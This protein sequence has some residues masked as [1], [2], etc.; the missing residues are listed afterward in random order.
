MKRLTVWVLILAMALAT[1]ATF[2]TMAMAKQITV[3]MLP[4]VLGEPY[5]IASQKGAELAAKELGIKFIF[6]GPVTADVTKQIEMIDNYI[7]RGVDVIAVSPNDANAIAPI[8]KKAMSKGIKVITW[9]ADA[10]PSARNFFVNQVTYEGVGKALV[11]VLADEIGGKGEVAIVTASLTAANQN[12]WIKYMKEELKDY[13][14]MKL[15]DIR[16]S[17]EDQQ[18]AFQVTTDLMTAYPNLRGVFAITSV[19]FPGAAEAIKQAGKGGKVAVTGLSTPKSMAKYVHEG[20]VKNVV[21]WDPGD[22]GYLAMYVAKQLVDG[23]MP[24]PGTDGTITAGKLGK[25]QVKADGE[26]ILGPPTVF[27]ARNIDKFDF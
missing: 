9:D 24:R 26:V 14:G 6:D 16:P 5:F 12:N 8:L 23:K 13:P 18:L 20:V 15:V 2:G 10:V 22:L 21:L 27:T 3:A 25:I 4:K 11:D 1:V 17:E 7:T 19:A